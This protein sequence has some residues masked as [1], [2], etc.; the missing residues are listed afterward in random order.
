M[1]KNRYFLLFICQEF[2][3]KISSDMNFMEI[4]LRALSILLSDSLIAQVYVFFVLT[5]LMSMVS[6]FIVLNILYDFIWSKKFY[7]FT[8]DWLR[9]FHCYVNIQ[10]LNP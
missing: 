10:H 8:E 9:P 7:L 4:F 6:I 2:W 5:H 3:H 1:D